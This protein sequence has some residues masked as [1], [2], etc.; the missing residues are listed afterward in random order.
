MSRKYKFGDSSKLYFIS[1]AV[2]HWIDLFIRKEYKNIVV[3]SEIFCQRLKYIHCNPVETG[4]VEN[5]EDY[6]Y[7]SARDFYIKMD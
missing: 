4:F 6:F 7:S 5:E 2:I 1:F 3:N